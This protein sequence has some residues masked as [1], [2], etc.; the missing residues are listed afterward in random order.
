MARHH[1][2]IFHYSKDVELAVFNPARIAADEGWVAREYR[3][4]DERGRYMVDNL[5]GAGTTK[6]PSGQ[7]WRGVDPAGI[8]AGRHSRYIPETLDRLDTEGRIHWPKKGQYPKLK[9]YLEDSD[10]TAVGDI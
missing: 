6:G 7:P 1:D 9:Q 3:F 10:G 4:E 5:T 2:V 8:G